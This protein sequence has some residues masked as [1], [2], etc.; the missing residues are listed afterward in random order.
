MKA[1]IVLS[2]LFVT[3]MPYVAASPG[4][5]GNIVPDLVKYHKYSINTSLLVFRVP[6]MATVSRTGRE[7]PGGLT[8]TQTWVVQG[9]PHRSGSWTYDTKPRPDGVHLIF[10]DKD[11]PLKPGDVLE[12]RYDQPGRVTFR[13]DIPRN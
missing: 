3:P 4:S 10:N 5:A 13:K 9:P 2:L 6:L 8:E 1:M 12:F 7:I 11:Y